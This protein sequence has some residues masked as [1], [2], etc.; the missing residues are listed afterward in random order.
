MAV[1]KAGRAMMMGM[2]LGIGGCGQNV[3]GSGVGGV[4][5]SEADALNDAAAMLDSRPAPAE[6]RT[7]LNP[8]AVRAAQERKAR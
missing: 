6:N 1:N 7:A 5:A 3:D 2:A 4:S 8:A